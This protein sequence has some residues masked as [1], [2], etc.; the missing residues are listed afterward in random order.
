MP[1]HRLEKSDGY[2]V[3]CGG[4]FSGRA[5]HRRQQTVCRSRKLWL[6]L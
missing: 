5:R 1:D 4:I 3:R 6:G 2:S